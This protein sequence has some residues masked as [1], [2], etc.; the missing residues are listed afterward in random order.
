MEK[1]EKGGHIGSRSHFKQGFYRTVQNR[2]FN[3]SEKK[4]DPLNYYTM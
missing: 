3:S 2:C 1:G 4:N